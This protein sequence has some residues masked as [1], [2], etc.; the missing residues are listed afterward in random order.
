MGN[1]IGCGSFSIGASNTNNSAG[2]AQFFHDMGMQTQSNTP[3][4]IGTASQQ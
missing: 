1:E 2:K 4:K 3:G